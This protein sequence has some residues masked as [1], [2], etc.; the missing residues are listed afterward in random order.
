MSY[1]KSWIFVLALILSAPMGL[2][3][4][5]PTGDAGRQKPEDL[6]HEWFKRWNALDGSP[7]SVNKLLELYHPDAVQLMGPR[8]GQIGPALYEGQRVIRTMAEQLSA[9][10][11]RL[12]YYVKART[13]QEKT[14]ELMYTTAMPW[15]GS[16]VAVEFG[17]SYDMRDTGKRFMVSGAAFFEFL[18]GR[19]SRLRLYHA[20][21]ETL[22][23]KP[24][25]TAGCGN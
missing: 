14:A 3:A 6:V 11:S 19:I 2:A 12:A 17:A 22:E 20:A 7:E 24:P 9:E 10:Y 25:F 15:G 16:A 21:G 23:V 4:Q 1:M 18:D 8:D 13:I 5:S